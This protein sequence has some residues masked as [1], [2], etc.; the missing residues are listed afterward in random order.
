M[1]IGKEA[2]WIYDMAED[3]A[4]EIMSQ[5]AG[6]QLVRTEK[7]SLSDKK[8][9]IVYAFLDGDKVLQ[10]QLAAEPKLFYRLAKNIIG[11]EPEDEAEIQEYAAEFANVLCGR[12]VSELCRMIKIAAKFRPTAYGA[13]P[14]QPVHH[15]DTLHF[16]SDESEEIT[17]SWDRESMKELLKRE[18]SMHEIMVVDDSRVV[19]AEM[20][21]MLA[22]SDFEIVK[23]CRSGEEALET[24]EGVK[25]EVVTMDIV[26][27]GIDGLDAAE[28]M[29]KK[30]PDA[31]VVMVSSLA[32]GDTIERA[33]SFGAKGF[34][35]KPFKK[36]DLI[37]ALEKA[38][39]DGE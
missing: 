6:I 20:K 3:L 12:F 16:L 28:E 26:M 37:G 9:D 14:P 21:K 23:F 18:M 39:K 25:P 36:D 34:L 27:P 22:D 7:D 4:C 13:P 15:L 29:L 8:T 2:R 10:M 11:D 1:T 17:F 5:M 24:Y 19:Y 38:L 30:W 31:R 33:S 35:F 32:Y